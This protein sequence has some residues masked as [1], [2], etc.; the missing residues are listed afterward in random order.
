M[1][2][3]IGLEAGRSCSVVRTVLT[4]A[5]WLARSARANGGG[6]RGQR[7]RLLWILRALLVVPLRH[8]GK[9][10]SRVLQVVCSG[11]G[12]EL[13][14]RPSG[15]DSA[16]WRCSDVEREADGVQFM[17]VGV[18]TVGD[19]DG[20]MMAGKSRMCRRLVFEN[21]CAGASLV[22]RVVTCPKRTSGVSTR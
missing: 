6:G 5:A 7:I 1:V 16:S 15:E 19:G 21:W 11:S 9:W 18:K 8:I 14:L 3:R 17:I 20:K 10:W 2:G 12:E 22:S 13:R 4:I